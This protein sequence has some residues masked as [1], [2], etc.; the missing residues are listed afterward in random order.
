MSLDTKKKRTLTIGAIALIAVVGVVW[1]LTSTG[2][3]ATARVVDRR[4]TDDSTNDEALEVQDV[5]VRSSPQSRSGRDRLEGASAKVADRADEAVAAVE[6]KTKRG[7]K[8]RKRRAQK[9][10][11][12]DEEAAGASN[13][14]P[15][16]PYGK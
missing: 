2:D 1:A 16:P 4:V 7:K 11:D 8:A 10:Q 13:K 14:R 9:Q 5:A 3:S 12:D 6:K 15:H